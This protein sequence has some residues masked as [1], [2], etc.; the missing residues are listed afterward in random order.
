[1]SSL[2]PVAEGGGR[3]VYHHPDYPD[4][5]LKVGKV[6]NPATAK[7]RVEARIAGYFPDFGTRDIRHEIKAYVAAM[8]QPGTGRESLPVAGFRGLIDSDLGLAM[9]VERISFE[10]R[11]LGPTVR[12]LARREGGLSDEHL[13]LL[14]TF[15]QLLF[16]WRVRA[17]DLNPGNIVLG[18]RDGRARFY[19]V[20]GLGD[21]TIIPLN[22]W[23][24]AA[25]RVELNRLLTICANSLRLR[26]DRRARA[27]R[28][29]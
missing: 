25:N 28:R 22:T 16:A 11:L 15:S 3:L 20:D 19:L 23:F 10:D 12:S 26:W 18:D 7:A 17:R 8:L 6:K 21:V 13:A 9:M 24:D 1:L 4:C 5:L 29:P 14:N 2:T 27:F